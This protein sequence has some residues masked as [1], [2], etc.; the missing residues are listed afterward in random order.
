VIS[1]ISDPVL[2]G[3]EREEEA[4]HHGSSNRGNYTFGGNPKIAVDHKVP[5]KALITGRL[6]DV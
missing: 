2:L 3:N 5:D 4:V 1:D 6:S